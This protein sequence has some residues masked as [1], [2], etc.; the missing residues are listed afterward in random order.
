MSDLEIFAQRLRSARVMNQLSMDKLI[1]KLCTV[2]NLKISKPAISKYENA[3]MMPSAEVKQALAKVLGVDEEYFLRPL[4]C[5][6]ETFT[7]NFRKKS[8][9]SVSAVKAL[10]EKV[11]DKVECYLEVESILERAN[12]AGPVEKLPHSSLIAT[13]NDARN[14]ARQLRNAWG[15]GNFPIVNVQRLLEMHGIKVIPIDAPDDFDGLSGTIDEDKIFVVINANPRKTHVERRRLTVMHEVGHQLMKFASG[16]MAREEEKLCNAFANEMLITEAA[17]N[18]ALDP[19]QPISLLT[20]R[21]LQLYYGISID[22]LMKKAEETNKISNSQ[23][24][25]YNIQKNSLQAFKQAVEKSLYQEP[26]LYDR[27]VG[28]VLRAY[29]LKLIDQEKAKSLLHGRT[30]IETTDLFA[31]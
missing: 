8:S 14:F 19:T 6:A 3:K 26:P 31:I 5:T 29:S 1:E 15:L 18:L 4:T 7:V 17:F 30:E 23:Y 24:T 2:C 12:A 20:L 27:Y 10:R 11:N 16:I 13:S 21:P 25:Y 28:M 22:A 9:M